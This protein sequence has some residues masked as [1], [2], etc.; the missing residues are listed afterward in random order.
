MPNPSKVGTGL[1]YSTLNL[2]WAT[3]ASIDYG[4][5]VKIQAQCAG[6][7]TVQ[8]NFA[9]TGSS[10][11][12]AIIYTDGVNY[13]G[14]NESALSIID[15]VNIQAVIDIRDMM[16]LSTNQFAPPLAVNS[17]SNGSKFERLRIKIEAWNGV[18][19]V[20]TSGSSPDSSMIN[21]VVSG[22]VNVFDFGFQTQLPLNQVIAFGADQDGFEGS[23][24]V[25][26][27]ESTFAFNNGANDYVNV[28]Q[29]T[30]ASEDGTG[31][32]TGYTSAELVDFAGGDYRTKS[33]SFLATAGD[34]GTFIGAFLEQSSSTLVDIDKATSQQTAS[35]VTTTETPLVNI[36]GASNTQTSD[37]I[38]LLQN[39]NVLI[40]KAQQ[41][42]TAS[43][44]S[45][46][47]S[48]VLSL[49]K[50]NQSQSSN[51]I[52][53]LQ[54]FVVTID[55]ASNSQTATQMTVTEIAQ[56]TINIAN[57]RNTQT[58]TVVSLVQDSIIS[59]DNGLQSQSTSIINFNGEAVGYLE[60]SLT[61]SM[62][63]N[64][65]LIA[66]SLGGSLEIN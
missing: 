42:Q 35:Q 31:T 18:D 64:G 43:V 1:D 8:T 33:T 19:C 49:N 58:G 47:Q 13:D 63:I 4:A 34:G 29:T 7:E 39:H 48:G 30:T 17:L 3:E 66:T 54:N 14:T 46:S 65:N 6:G 36:N 38:T 11:N 41:E 40:D 55:K 53:L 26:P 44:I 22:G 24:N 50:A 51:E 57:A 5:G 32:F 23:G 60:G 10:V 21:S 28:I 56:G 20:T 15:R 52:T 37:V 61:I 59:I 12:G 2:W 16:I 27:L 9:P 25:N 45:L 62:S